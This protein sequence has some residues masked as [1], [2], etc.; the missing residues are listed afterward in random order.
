VD[1]A[2]QVVAQDTRG[3]PATKHYIVDKIVA[4]GAQDI[5]HGT[6]NQAKGC[7]TNSCLT[8]KNTDEPIL[9]FTLSAYCVLSNNIVITNIV[10]PRTG[11]EALESTQATMWYA[12]V[13]A[14]HLHNAMPASGATVGRA[15]YEGLQVTLG[16][17]RLFWLPV[18]GAHAQQ[19]IRTPPKV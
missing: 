4:Q 17:F 6:D 14:N 2:E 19:A 15:P 7:Q 12:L 18:V 11:D 1:I 16:A 13:Y 8:G 10:K 5:P 9:R 3:V